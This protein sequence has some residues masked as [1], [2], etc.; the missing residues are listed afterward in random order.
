MDFSNLGRSGAMRVVDEEALFEAEVAEVES[1]WRSDRFRLTRRPYTARE[2]VRLRGSLKQHY[3]SNEMAKKLWHI[4]KNHQANKTCS[5]TFGSLDPVQVAQMAKYLDT[6]YVS[7]WQCA[8]TAATSNEPGPDLADYPMDTVPNKVE[9]LFFAQ[10]FHD[11]KQ[12]EA[13]LSMTKEQRARTPYVDYLAPLIADGDTGFGGTTATVKLCKMFVE[14][15]AA[16]IHMEDQASVTKKC[17]HMG[18]KVLVATSEHI[19]R[20]VAARLQFDV[21]GVEQVLVARSDSVAASLI[22]SNIDPRDH[23]FILGASNPSV[24][25]RALVTVLSAALA[26]G[27]AGAELQAIEDAWMEEADLRLFADTVADAIRKMEVAENTKVSRLNEWFDKV[28]QLSHIEAVVLAEKLGVTNLFWDWDLP[29]TREGFYRFQGSTKAAIARGCAFAPYA[30]LLWMETATPDALQAREFAEGVK[31]RHPEVMLAYNLSP[32]FNWDAAGMN[33][34]QMQS[35]I[36]DLAKMGFCWQFITLAG[37]HANSL[38]VDTFARDFAQRGML[39]YVQDIQRQERNN[40]VETL[41]H[42][43]WSGA[44]YYDQLL[45]TVTGGISSTA[46]MQKGVTEDQFK[47]VWGKGESYS[48]SE[49]FAKAKL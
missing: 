8:S 25:G 36:P 15:G 49:V 1:W 31:A 40:G 37:F 9:H 27:K 16:G 41:A 17:G 18:G 46:A 6:I 23:S 3:S 24:H 38:V 30:D 14:R 39:A 42:Q 13:R 26:A 22:Q 4:L 20:L 33:D 48:S 19:N 44:N 43:T 7:G 34:A 45:K 32:S 11:K 28:E 10:I 2:V 29:R 21:M 47:D 35:F 5:R 12:R